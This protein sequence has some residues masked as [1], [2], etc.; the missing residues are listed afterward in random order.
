MTV[1]HGDYAR[2][3]EC[4]EVDLANDEGMHVIALSDTR[5]EFRVASAAMITSRQVY[6]DIAFRLEARA[7]HAGSGPA[8]VSTAYPMIMV[9]ASSR[10]S[11]KRRSA[12]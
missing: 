1:S 10:P 7:A 8:S 2:R 9:S 3:D 4:H 11:R 6:R 12:H 5:V